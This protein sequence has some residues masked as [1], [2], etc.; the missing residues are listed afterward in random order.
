MRTG[1]T[2][3]ATAPARGVRTDSLCLRWPAWAWAHAGGV[4][5]WL[6]MM[7]VPAVLG[8]Q[9][10]PPPDFESGHQL[11]ATPVPPARSLYLEYLDVAVLV[12]A[13]GLATCFV[14]KHRSRK[15]ILGLSL[16]SLG[17]FGFYRKGCV[18]AIGAVQ[19]VA[20][21]LSDPAYALPLPALAF[22]VL[23]LVVALFAG[24][25]F[26]AG[27]C[28]H[29]ALQD[30]V[31]IKPVTV[32]RWLEQGLSLVPYIYLGAGVAL[33]AAGGAYIICRYDPFVPLFR[34]SGS[35]SLL[36]AG[37]GFLLLG[38]FVGRPYCRF[39]CPY[40]ALLRVG[41]AVSKWRVTITPGACT[42]CRLCE[43]ACP[44]GA[45]REPTVTPS[46]SAALTVDRR[47][48]T[49]MLLLLPVLVV[50]GGF[51]G[52]S[53]A[54]MAARVHP[55]VALSERYLREK[56]NPV[57]LGVQSAAALALNRAEQN[58]K[59]LLSRAVEIR[60]RFGRAGLIFGWWMGLVVAVKLIGLSL[61]QNRADYEPDRGACLGC[62]RCF[63][64]CPEE[65][66]R[67]GLCPAGPAGAEE[68]APATLPAGN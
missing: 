60:Q 53:L 40:G 68:R 26:C 61:H 21:A 18:C 57:P 14:L 39:L 3:R 51:V 36:L 32:P 27:V 19:N 5:V 66:V 31:L 55:S 6:V 54:P 25:A 56:A 15:A 48:L 2:T 50:A 28:P 65:R 30:L 58:P 12:L 13:L 11:P 20:V 63:A 46:G 33:A 7:A 37:A 34:L 17:Y 4:L 59:E 67:A 62:G 9:R 45:I 64:Y 35:M 1:V 47:R 49:W 43:E 10:F 44:Y 29:G 42:R 38:M 52:S 16:F 22:F 24:R 8:E 23:P 41:A